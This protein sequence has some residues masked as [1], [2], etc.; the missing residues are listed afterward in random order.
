MLQFDI[1][2]LSSHFEHCSDCIEERDGDVVYFC[3]RLC[4][5]MHKPVGI[6]EG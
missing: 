4:Y 6:E 1:S 2:A 5:A 3:G